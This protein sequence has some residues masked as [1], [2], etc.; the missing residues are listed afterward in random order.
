MILRDSCPLALALLAV[1]IGLGFF[2]FLLCFLCVFFQ[3]SDDMNDD[4]S[5]AAAR[6]A[7][8]FSKLS[9]GA[10]R[11]ELKLHF[12]ICPSGHRSVF[13]KKTTPLSAP[14]AQG[15][16]TIVVPAVP[17][18]PSCAAAASRVRRQLRSGRAHHLGVH[19][20]LA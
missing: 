19:G 14:I 2:C 12:R 10:H 17:A 8:H 7:Y 20:C 3:V 9:A 15:A 4:W 1:L 5:S 13:P 6:W 16:F 11:V 18:A